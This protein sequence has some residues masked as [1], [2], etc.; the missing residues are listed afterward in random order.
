MPVAAWSPRAETARA[1]G[2]RPALCG[3]HLVSLAFSRQ[4]SYLASWQMGERHHP[5]QGAAQRTASLFSPGAQRGAT[6][7]A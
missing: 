7:P 4:V 1:A 6:M 2:P 5:R 3:P